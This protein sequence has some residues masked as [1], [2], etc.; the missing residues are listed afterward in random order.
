MTYFLWRSG[1]LDNQF[2]AVSAE[3]RDGV[4][5]RRNHKFDWYIDHAYDRVVGEIPTPITAEIGYHCIHCWT[6]IAKREEIKLM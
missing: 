3:I 5:L 2:R 1:T 6:S 4:T